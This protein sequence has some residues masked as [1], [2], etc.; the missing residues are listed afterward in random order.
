VDIDPRLPFWIAA[1]LSLANGLYG[2]FVLP[3]SLP[4]ERRAPFSWR[5]ANPAG[6]LMLLRSQTALT[7]LAAV[8][9]LSFLAHAALPSIGVLYMMDRYGW[10]GSTVGLTM[11]G[12]GIASIVVQGVVTA[13][14]VKRFGERATL[15]AGLAFGVAGFAIMGLA[16]TGPVF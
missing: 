3:E 16:P 8:N 1:G 11:A 13:R 15:L 7:R 9:F 6:A 2:L 10:S 5:R 14:A 4:K 12:V